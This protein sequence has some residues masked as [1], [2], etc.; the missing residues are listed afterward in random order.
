MLHVLLGN[1]QSN[2]SPPPS[3]PPPINIADTGDL[4]TAL[5]A[6]LRAVESDVQVR[7]CP[8]LG[9]GGKV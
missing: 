3:P 9:E 6:H 1:S 2:T 4:L 8:I 5:D 7:Q